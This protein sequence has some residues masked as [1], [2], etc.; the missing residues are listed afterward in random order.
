MSIITKEE[1]QRKYQ[2]A[3]SVRKHKCGETALTFNHHQK[4]FGLLNMDETKEQMKLW[5]TWIKEGKIEI[6]AHNN[7]TKDINGKKWYCLVVNPKPNNANFDP[8]GVM[9][10]GELVNG[11]IYAFDKE[12]NRNAAFN[13]ANR[14]KTE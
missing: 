8:F 12:V 1:V 3:L 10:L 9:V 14:I 13:Y 11:F 5:R 4:D 2:H 6:I 7:K